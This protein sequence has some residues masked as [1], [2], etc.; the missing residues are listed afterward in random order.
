[1]SASFWFLESKKTAE[2]M[3]EGK[4]KKEIE[5]LALNE[6]FYQFNSKRRIKRVSNNIYRRLNH[7]SKNL[8]E[9]FLRLDSNSAKIFVLIS[10]LVDDKLFFE[11]MYDIFKDKI[12]LGDLTLKQKDFDIFFN[13]KINESDIVA[14]WTETTINK[15]KS[16]YRKILFEAGIIKEVDDGWNI[17]IPLIDLNLQKQLIDEGYGPV[18]Y[19]ITGEKLY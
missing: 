2:L 9:L 5:I 7:F 13:N 19:A 18:L 3:V 11:F 15:L 8:L 17:I 4:S 1:M 14:K 16:I 6:N 12:I 10:I